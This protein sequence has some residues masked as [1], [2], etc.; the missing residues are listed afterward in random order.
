M[1]N[2]NV[3]KAIESLYDGRCDV[4]GYG[5]VTNTE[6]HLTCNKEYTIYENVPCRLSVKSVVPSNQGE[7]VNSVAQEVKLFLSPDYNIKSGCKIVVTQ[8]GV[9]TVYKNSGQPN[10]KSNHQE[11]SVE[12]FKEW[13]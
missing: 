8:N 11:I 7:P 10:V 4:Y 13:S 1:V 2:E 9:T 6:S 3:K 12:L 5:A